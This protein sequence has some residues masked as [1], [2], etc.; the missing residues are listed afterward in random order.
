[1]KNNTDNNN[2][3]DKR[4]RNA[5]LE[6]IYETDL[7]NFHRTLNSLLDLEGLAENAT[8]S[9]K[10]FLIQ[11][12]KAYE[13]KKQDGSAFDHEARKKKM[14]E[15]LNQFN[16]DCEISLVNEIFTYFE[17]PI[18]EDAKEGVIQA[19]LPCR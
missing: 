12:I 15:I 17:V 5:T 4:M 13:S 16:C 6:Q 19:F 7:K 18:L 9:T 3:K 8:R 2:D 1:M 14:K 11:Y 10:A